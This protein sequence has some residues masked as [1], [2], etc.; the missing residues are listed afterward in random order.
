MMAHRPILDSIMQKI[1][2]KKNV[3]W[4]GCSRQ[5]LINLQ[6]SEMFNII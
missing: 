5:V 2:T 1:E 6:E 3:D 4:N